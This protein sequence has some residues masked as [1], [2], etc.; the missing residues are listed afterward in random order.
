VFVEH[1]Y[2][3]TVPRKEIIEATDTQ[4]VSMIEADWREP[5][6]RFLAKQE[7][8]YWRGRSSLVLKTPGNNG[9]TPGNHCCRVPH[10]GIITRE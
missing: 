6:I 10:S 5:L 1:L 7:L 4:E 3:P 9:K 2:E 8:H